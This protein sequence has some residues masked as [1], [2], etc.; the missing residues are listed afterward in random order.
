MAAMIGRSERVGVSRISHRSRAIGGVGA[1]RPIRAV[2]AIVIRDGGHEGILI[3]GRDQARIMLEAWWIL[4]LKSLGGK[5]VQHRVN[6]NKALWV[7]ETI[8]LPS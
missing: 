5:L 4:H 7:H 6:L 1:I 8:A 3:R 2:K